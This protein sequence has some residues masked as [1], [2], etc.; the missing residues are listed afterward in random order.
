MDEPVIIDLPLEDIR[1]PYLKIIEP[2]AGKRLITSIEVLSPDNKARGPGRRSYL[3]K[4]REVRRSRANLVEIDLLRDGNPPYPGDREDLAELEPWHYLIAVTRRPRQQE[5][6]AIPLQKRLPRIRVPL[7]PKDD[8][9]RLDL[10]AAFQRVWQGGP[11][12]EL[13]E[14]DGDPPG[15]MKQED[16]EWCAKQLRKAGLRNGK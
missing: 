4:R 1:Q 13:L 7:T 12:P 6:Y 2:A 14:Y 11:Y 8:D 5:V 15:N 3:K 9:V 16:V 10:Q